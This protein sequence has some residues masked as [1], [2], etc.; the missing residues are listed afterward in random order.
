MHFKNICADV[1]GKLNNV[2][3]PMPKNI[4]CWET[5]MV[6]VELKDIEYVFKV[7]F[8]LII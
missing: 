8:L 6:D 4:N 7:L 2:G 3:N 1:I 5:V